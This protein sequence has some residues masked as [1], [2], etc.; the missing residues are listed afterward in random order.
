MKLSLPGFAH[1][2]EGSPFQVQ[3]AIEKAA[4]IK[5]RLK[6]KPTLWL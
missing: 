4:L 2:G 3:G 5:G 1:P 6:R